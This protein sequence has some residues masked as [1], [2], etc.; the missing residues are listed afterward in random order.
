MSSTV[1]SGGAK[2]PPNPNSMEQGTE[3]PC[4]GLKKGWA[5]VGADGVVL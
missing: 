2:P 1:S 4:R 3:E 5:G